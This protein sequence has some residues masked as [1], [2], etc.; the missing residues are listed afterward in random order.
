MIAWIIEHMLI[1]GILLGFFMLFLKNEINHQWNRVYLLTAMIFSCLLPFLPQMAIGS[2]TGSLYQVTLP[3]LTIGTDSFQIVEGTTGLGGSGFHFLWIAGSLIY[4][5]IITYSLI[6]LRTIRSQ[7]RM[8]NGI[9]TKTV[10]EIHSPFSFLDTVYLPE[11]QRFSE[12][13]LE[14]ILIHEMTHIRLRHSWDILLMHTFGLLIWWN[15]LFYIYQ[16]LLKNIHEYQ[17]DEQVIRSRDAQDYSR[18]LW[19]SAIAQKSLRLAHPIFHQPLKNRIIMIK[20]QLNSKSNNLKYLLVIPVLALVMITHSCN[21]SVVQSETETSQIENKDVSEQEV[22]KVADEMP[23][24][25]GCEDLAGEER[26]KCAN[27]KLLEYVYTQVQ[28]PEAAKKE[29]IEGT[30]IS[31]FVVSSDGQVY[32]I[33]IL[34]DPGAQCGEEVLRILKKMSAEHIWVPGRHNG[35]EVNVAFTLPVKFKMG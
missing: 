12:E 34:K 21:D 17:A 25:P 1:S 28:Y 10:K 14:S 22:L 30:V 31:R 32:D 29:G 13:D 5:A 35:K 2:L 20:R 15:P 7:T 24:F 9:K 23:R 4:A 11:E 8:V 3:A 16:R 27:Q 33:E 19:Q 18:L 6:R 26:Q